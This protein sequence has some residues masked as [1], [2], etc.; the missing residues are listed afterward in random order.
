[1]D[2]ENLLFSDG[3]TAGDVGFSFD[4]GASASGVDNSVMRGDTGMETPGM[5]APVD[6]LEP[7]NNRFVRLFEASAPEDRLGTAL[8]GRGELQGSGQDK[9]GKAFMASYEASAEHPGLMEE[10]FSVNPF[11]KEVKGAAPDAGGSQAGGDTGQANPVAPPPHA[12]QP[13][14]Q[15]ASDK[16]KMRPDLGDSVKE[17][18]SGDRGAG[19]VSNPRADDKG[20]VSYGTYQFTSMHKG[21]V[22]GTVK[23]FLESQEGK[24]Y[25][26]EFSGLVPGSAEFSNKWREISSREPEALHQ[27]ERDFIYRTHYLPSAKKADDSGLDIN[28][29]A[30][31]DMVWSTSVQHGPGGFRSVLNNTVKTDPDLRTKSAED[32]LKEI[33]WARSGF[34]G[35]NQWAVGGGRY[36]GSP[37]KQPGEFEVVRARNEAYQLEK[38]KMR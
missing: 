10:G 14:A 21:A 27:A 32:Q 7:S 38:A 17:F 13:G 12:G 24:Q 1:M 19:T 20:G 22:G 23:V 11:M 26:P 2:G 4:P 15:S 35:P 30:I 8:F 16:F 9:D 31:Q 33:Y 28:N 36:F 29:P 25:A 5:A 3:W 37:Q 6:P 18:E 34:V